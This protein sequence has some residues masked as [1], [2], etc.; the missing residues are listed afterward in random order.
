MFSDMVAFWPIPLPILPFMRLS[1]IASIVFAAL[2]P[3]LA[4]AESRPVPP[5][6]PIAS[7]AR[8]D[9]YSHPVMSPDGKHLAMTVRLPVGARTVPMV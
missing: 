4:L 5:L 6:V 8:T 9:Q 3:V 7:F 1:P 2:L